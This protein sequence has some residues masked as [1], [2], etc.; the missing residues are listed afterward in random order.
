LLI[1]SAAVAVVAFLFSDHVLPRSNHRLR[2][3]LMDIA[4]KKPT[5][6]LK[7]QVINEVQRARLFLRAGRID[8]STF[9]L[10]DVTLY[11]MGDQERSRVVYADS[12]YMA[13]TPNQEDLHL[14]LFD[15]IMHEFNRYDPKIFQQMRFRRD[16]I[17]VAGVGNALDR[18]E[19]DSFRGDR[20]VSIC[21]M[22]DVIASAR[23]EQLQSERR[24]AALQESDL[25]ALVGL[26]PL[27][28]DTALPPAEPSLY[29]RTI[30]RLVT[31]LLPTELGAQQRASPS[32]QGGRRD[33]LGPEAARFTQPPPQK[34]GYVAGMRPVPRWGE[35]SSLRERA[36]GARIREANYQV[37][38]H[39]K[40]AI[41]A[42]CIVFVLIGVPA[43]LRFPR[44]GV[45]L[46]IGL[47]MI[48]FT[49]YYVG[50]IA[51]ETLGN[52][53][54]IPPFLAM[55]SSNIVFSAAG[56]FWL[57]RIRNQG[58]GKAA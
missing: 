49:I 27:V 32:P 9:Q 31:A 55:W 2:T 6:A 53:R 5:F 28:A 17:R 7:E 16:V 42:A 50:L 57:W 15:G 25:R 41:A 52:H 33:S 22:N 37:E 11:D 10:L 26:G 54:V 51:G 35:V 21:E 34:G 23:R 20:E 43:A 48:V 4:R 3:L 45:G 24:A 56:L 1:A 36:R 18:S 19:S 12:G 40:R 47:S 30:G 29:C 39:K 46:V 8:Q 44:G 58:T 38:A 14:T 13:I